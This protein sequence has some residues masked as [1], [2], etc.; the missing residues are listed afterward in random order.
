MG[1]GP[2]APDMTAS[3]TAAASQAAIALEQW[4]TTKA[5][6]PQAMARA[7][8][9][10]ARAQDAADQAKS[11]STYYRG[12]ADHQVKEAAKAEPYQQRMRD[13]ADMYSSGRA[14]NDQ[15]GRDSAD[16]EQGFGDATGAMA[17]SAGRLG[18][19]PGSDSFA[20]T[21][22]DMYTQKALAS[23]G[24]RTSA[25]ANARTKAEG[26]VAQAAGSGQTSFSNGM[27]AGGM[28]GG[29]SAGSVGLGASGLGGYNNVQATFN[30]GAS[31]AAGQYGQV[32]SSYRA[33]AIESA[34]S[35]GFDFIA[36]LATGGLKAWG[37]GGFNSPTK[38]G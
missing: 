6:L 11:D 23:A 28:A 26:L 10:D 16:V 25:R 9:E 18:L 22:G 19:N 8:R 3:N 32:S 4:N 1:W 21:L 37:A 31:G 12:L 30:N 2:A 17:R 14:G 33:N 5:Y 24:A 13:T 36:G 27:G 7:G 34:R 35:P 15:A 29:F 20:S 38:P